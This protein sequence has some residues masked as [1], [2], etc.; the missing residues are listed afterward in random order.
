MPHTNKRFREVLRQLDDDES[1]GS[2]LKSKDEVERVP[3]PLTR[4]T[5]S[6]P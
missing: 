1:D 2:P 3:H 6:E 5:C 4:R